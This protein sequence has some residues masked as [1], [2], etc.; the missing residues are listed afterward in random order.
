MQYLII[1]AIIF[2]AGEFIVRFIFRLIN[3]SRLAKER[4]KYLRKSLEVDYSHISPTLKRTQ[5]EFPKA[6]VLIVE[7]DENLLNMM[8]ET[9]VRSGY[10]VDSVDSSREA[11]ELI[12]RTHYDFCFCDIRDGGVCGTEATSCIRSI[13]PDIDVIVMA[14]QL[15]FESGTDC[16][17]HGAMAYLQKP[18]D[19][20]TL[21]E[22]IGENLTKRREMIHL[23]L[24]A[25][26]INQTPTSER[27]VDINVPKGI[28]FADWHTW[29][30]LGRDGNIRVGLNDLAKK[31]IGR[32]DNI[33]FPNLGMRVKRGEFLFGVMQQHRL[34]PMRSP[35]TGTVIKI[36][37]TLAADFAVFEEKAYAGQWIC[38]IRPDNL[39]EDLAHLKIGDQAETYI[40]GEVRRYMNEFPTDRQ[41]KMDFPLIT[42]DAMDAQSF[43][44]AV[45]KMFLR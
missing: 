16:L 27:V 36:N 12:R 38:V 39:Q 41:T 11:V 18:F 29:A 24:A 23:N 5:I 19:E 26:Y 34:I 45:N 31:I 14:D 28:F 42:L 4:E 37:R 15:T 6:R 2:I 43:D 3:R 32:M 7:R 17:K 22:F 33:E 9:L 44:R 25:N 40:Y 8:R 13:R 30:L 35:V 1:A 10:S 20:K 21:I